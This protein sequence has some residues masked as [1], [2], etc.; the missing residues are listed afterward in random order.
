[1]TGVQTCALPIWHQAVER[2]IAVLV[3]EKVTHAALMNAVWGAPTNGLLRDATLFDVYRPKPGTGP[4]SDSAGE[5][6]LAVRLTL[7]SDAATLTDE[8]IDA[9]VQAVVAQ[10]V[11]DLG[12]RQR[13]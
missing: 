8:Q 6:S 7:G 3:A 10:L 9:S 13:A 2:D 11:A 5:K 4:V 1:M 12:A